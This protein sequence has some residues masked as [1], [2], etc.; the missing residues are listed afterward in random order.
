MRTLRVHARISWPLSHQK[1]FGL[2]AT[3]M[4]G[5]CKPPHCKILCVLSTAAQP[6][7]VGKRSLQVSHASCCI[8]AAR[9]SSSAARPSNVGKGNLQFLH[10][11]CCIAA[12]RKTLVSNMAEERGKRT[13]SILHMN[14]AAL[15]QHEKALANPGL[16]QPSTPGT[17]CQPSKDSR[18]LPIDLKD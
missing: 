13:P 15:R 1:A 4:A 18:L 10:A 12:A 17:S 2:S 5:F 7:N 14:D 16:F 8:A 3:K 11:S 6:R 9:K